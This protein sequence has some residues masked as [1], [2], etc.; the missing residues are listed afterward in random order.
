MQ[1]LISVTSAT[2]EAMALPEQVRKGERTRAALVRAAI[3]RFA[4]EGFQRVSLTDVARDVGVSPTAVYRYFPDKEALF[5]AAVDADAE[6]LVIFARDA[7]TRDVDGSLLELLGRLAAGLVTAA[8][9]HPLVARVL[10]GADI[11]TPARILAL[12]TLAE[13]RAELAELLRYG[14]SAGLVRRD[15]DPAVAALGLE[16]VVLNQVAY[17]VACG[18]VERHEPDARWTAVV[19]LLDAALRPVPVP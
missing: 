10:A 16:T 1:S 7:L 6:A 11:M 14:Q 19:A 13:F 4:S 8:H 9:A 3:G 12:P 17:L 18:T 15:L 5:E 2:L